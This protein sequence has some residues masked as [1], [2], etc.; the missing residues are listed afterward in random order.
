MDAHD[1]FT[2]ITRI[3]DMNPSNFEKRKYHRPAGYA[4]T[5]RVHIGRLTVAALNDT[6]ASCSCITEEQVVLIVN[7][8]MRMLA[9]KKIKTTDRNY[10]IGQIYEYED[11]AE[12][13]GAEKVGRM[14][15]EYAITLNVE[16]IADGN[17]EGVVKP[18]YF[19][20]FKYGTC[21]INGLVF[22][23]PTLDQPA[24]PGDEG[25]GWINHLDGVEYS[26]LGV[27]LPRLDDHRK[28]TYQ[29]SDAMYKNSGGQFCPLD[30]A[31]NQ[32]SE[33]VRFIDQDAARQLRIATLIENRI[34][35]AQ[36]AKKTMEFFV[37]GPGERAVV[38]CFWTMSGAERIT[39]C[40]THPEAPHGLVVLPGVCD[41][42][43][44]MS[45]VVENESPLPVTV[46]EK[47][48]LAVG[49]DEDG[50]PSLD[51]CAA[52]QDDQRKF[53]RAM[54]WK[55]AGADTERIAESAREDQEIV[56]VTHFGTTLFCMHTLRVK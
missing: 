21:G 14:Q 23:W 53:C 20:I 44:R 32:V 4:A 26:A 18:I 13:K 38:P 29:S 6:G 1:K 15:V 17:I 39:A 45:I 47:D 36:M 31:T 50:V 2:P 43:D 24:R 37:I 12:L 28:Q 9:E 42:G 30:D 33:N 49:V 8:T 52:V 19:K 25:L 35:T 16:F 55:G 54:D 51:A 27:T 40:S 22:G 34:P 11:V 5:T 41:S 7:H 10:P 3:K 56:I 46:T 48:M